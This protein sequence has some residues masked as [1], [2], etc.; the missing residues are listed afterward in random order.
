MEEVVR[1]DLVVVGVE[2]KPGALRDP[3]TLVEQVSM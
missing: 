3:W 1:V 2:A